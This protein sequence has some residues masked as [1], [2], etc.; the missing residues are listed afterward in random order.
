MALVKDKVIVTC[1]LTGVLAKREQCPYL[2]YTP[3]EIAEEAQRAY[4]AGAAVVHIHGREPDDGRPVAGARTS[5]G[6]SSDEVQQALPDHHQ[7]LHRRLQHGGG[8]RRRRSAR[9][10]PTSRRRGR[11]WR[12]STWAR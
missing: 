6:R 4:D 5:T 10:S 7:L 2:P 12:P 11:R 8:G 3:V 1:A 9:G